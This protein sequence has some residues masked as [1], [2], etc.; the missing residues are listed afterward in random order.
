MN[1][2]KFNSVMNCDKCKFNHQCNMVTDC[3]YIEGWEDG[4]RKLLN[5]FDKSIQEA[6]GG[7]LIDR[8][9]FAKYVEG[10]NGQ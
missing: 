2:W 3:P 9:S 10:K 7:K 8:G 4:Q 5:V 6:T 1:D